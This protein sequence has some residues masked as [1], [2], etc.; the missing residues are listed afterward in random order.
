MGVKEQLNKLGMSQTDLARILGVSRQ[1]VYNWCNGTVPA[2][3]PEVTREQI[4][5][6]LQTTPLE[7]WGEK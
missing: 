4:A 3:T 1:H 5:E 7:L 6:A 2:K